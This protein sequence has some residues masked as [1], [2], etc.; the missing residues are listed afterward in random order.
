MN[1]MRKAIFHKQKTVCLDKERY[2]KLYIEVMWHWNLRILFE[3]VCKFP[4]NVTLTY[5]KDSQNILER[6][7]YEKNYNLIYYTVL[8]SVAYQGWLNCSFLLNDGL[9]VTNLHTAV[10]FNDSFPIQRYC[11]Y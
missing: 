2:L 11:I 1:I 8:Y 7:V 10:V 4:S 9:G 6:L 5:E 3:E